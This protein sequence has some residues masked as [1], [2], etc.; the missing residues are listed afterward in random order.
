[1][2]QGIVEAIILFHQKRPTGIML[3]KGKKLF[4]GWLVICYCM[5]IVSKIRNN[6]KLTKKKD[7]FANWTIDGVLW[8]T[9][10]IQ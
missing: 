1:M 9:S 2:Y 5:Q 6:S 8:R 10:S 3:F 4:F 7:I